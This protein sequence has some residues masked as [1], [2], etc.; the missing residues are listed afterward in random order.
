[1][2][3]WTP[4][5]Y[6]PAFAQAR[7]GAS[8]NVAFDLLSIFDALSWVGRVGS[9]FLAEF[10]FLQPMQLM[11]LSVIGASIFL[12]AWISV[13]SF[14]SCVVFASFF[15]LFRGVLTTLP[16]AIVPKLSP[17]S[18]IV[19]TRLGMVWIFASIGILVGAPTSG[20][21]TNL[22]NHDFV[23]ARIFS[24]T[25]MLAGAISMLVPWMVITRK[26]GE[27]APTNRREE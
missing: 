6:L 22:S 9:G 11:I 17:S 15:G 18:D 19:G 1:M 5:F 13:R 10:P 21:L 25:V 4:F 26:E 3:Y 12:F 14:G 27:T 24:R 2:T 8:D 20:A 23:R 7:A 16:M